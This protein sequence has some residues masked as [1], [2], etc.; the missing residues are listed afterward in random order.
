MASLV[1]VPTLIEVDLGHVT[2][3]KFALKLKSYDAFA[4]SGELVEVWGEEGLAVLILTGGPLRR[5]RLKRLV[6][7]D[8]PVSFEV[9]TFADLG[10]EVTG[11]WS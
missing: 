8:S 3:Q 11:G 6:P 4:L 9:L 10:V 1:G 5:A 7:L 2:P